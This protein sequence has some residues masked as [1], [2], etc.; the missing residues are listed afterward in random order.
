MERTFIIEYRRGLET[1]TQE[2]KGEGEDQ[3]LALV[4]ALR[5]AGIGRNDLDAIA[6]IDHWSEKK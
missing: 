6:T 4:N 5:K 2:I 1:V 3:F